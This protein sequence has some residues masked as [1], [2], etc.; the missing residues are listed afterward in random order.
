MAKKRFKLSQ[1]QIKRLLKRN[2]GG[3]IASDRITVDGARVGYMTRDKPTRAE[4]SG[5]LFTAG[6]ETQDYMDDADNFAVYDVNTIANYDRDIIPFLDASVGSSFE[7]IADG[8]LEPCEGTEMPDPNATPGWPPPGFPIVEGKHALT[9]TW[10]L[11]LPQPFARR[12]EDGSL[13]LWRPGITLWIAAFNNDQNESQASRLAELAASMS[14]EARDRHDH[15]A[16]GV[17]RMRYRITED[18]E[19]L[20]ALAIADSGHLQLAVYFDDPADERVAIQIVDSI[21]L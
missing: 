21:T 14:P 15:V 11:T 16:G 19:T 9:N 10:S 13:V 12:I 8:P 3:C 6:D 17:T 18:A 4:D 5:W 1:D 20:M 2:Y 7:R